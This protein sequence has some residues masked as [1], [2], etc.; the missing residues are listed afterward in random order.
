MT[1]VS[2]DLGKREKGKGAR[3]STYFKRGRAQFI[4][5]SPEFFILLTCTH[6]YH[7]CTPKIKEIPRLKFL[8]PSLP[9]LGRWRPHGTGGTSIKLPRAYIPVKVEREVE[10][11]A[12]ALS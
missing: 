5:G 12:A 8:P 3:E 9:I 7:F 2:T 1:W 4:R 6:T 11:K 10:S